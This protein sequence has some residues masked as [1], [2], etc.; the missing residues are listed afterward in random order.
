MAAKSSE[1]PSAEPDEENLDD[2]QKEEYKEMLE[3]LGE[4]AVRRPTRFME[5][6]ADDA[7]NGTSL[8]SHIPSTYLYRCVL[9]DRV[10]INSLSMIAEDYSD[11]SAGASTI[12]QMIRDRLLK[13]PRNKL[14]PL[15]YA[16]DSILKNAKGHYISEVEADAESWIPAVY[17]QLQEPQKAKLEK[18]WKTWNDSRIFA[19]EKLKAMGRCFDAGSS[20]KSLASGTTSEVAGISRTVRIVI[21]DDSSCCTI[22]RKRSCDSFLFFS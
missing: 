10:K 1:P 20:G 15:V 11:S 7:Y 5:H 8:V 14:I 18:M 22:R 12:Y 6:P 21:L 13:A 16:V 17:K 3:N 4:F 19:P 2:E 9:Q